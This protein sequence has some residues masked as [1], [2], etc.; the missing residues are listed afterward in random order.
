MNAINVE[1]RDF[2]IKAKQLRRSGMIP[3]SI[4]GG[5]LP[6][7]ISIQMEEGVAF[8]LLRRKREG[9]K[10]NLE[11]DGQLIPVQLKEKM[12]NTL[13]NEILDISFQALKADKKVNSVIHIVLKNTEVITESLEVML[14]EIPYA[15]LP[16]D[17]IDTITIDVNG[18]G[19]GSIITVGDIPELASEK[20][21]LQVDKEEIVLRIR[22][23][24]AVARNAIEQEA[25]QA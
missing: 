1:K 22:D 3:G 21:E 5:P 24:N 11:L 18:M 15:A 9:S 17:M 13:S 23:K 4:F 14:L 7:A 10:L 25:A 19:I 6:D 8:K 2:S 16:E 20:I 12:I